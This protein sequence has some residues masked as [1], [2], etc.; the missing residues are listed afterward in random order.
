[1]LNWTSFCIRNLSILFLLFVV[2]LL[3]TAPN[4][5]KS[6]EVPKIGGHKHLSGGHAPVATGLLEH[7]THHIQLLCSIVGKLSFPNLTH[8]SVASKFSSLELSSNGRG[9]LEEASSELIGLATAFSLDFFISLLFFWALWLLATVGWYL[10]LN[11]LMLSEDVSNA[12]CCFRLYDVVFW[13]LGMGEMALSTFVGVSAEM[14]GNVTSPSLSCGRFKA[15]LLD[16][17]FCLDG[18]GRFVISTLIPGLE[19]LSTSIAVSAWLCCEVMFK[20]KAQLGA[21]DGLNGQTPK[22]WI[23]LLCCAIFAA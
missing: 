11:L 6:L 13:Y 22:P 14:R 5:T 12:A 16:E 9:P 4:K 18:S 17:A 19:Q 7:P 21:V 23:H 3:R 8:S 20:L 2:L 15:W 1:M 10:T